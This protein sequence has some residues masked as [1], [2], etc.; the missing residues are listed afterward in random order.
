MYANKN[1]QN[2][3]LKGITLNKVSK[4]EGAIYNLNLVDVTCK[5]LAD[6][7]HP[8]KKKKED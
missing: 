5:L 4:E 1:K 3:N 7:K 6:S 2:N 8:V